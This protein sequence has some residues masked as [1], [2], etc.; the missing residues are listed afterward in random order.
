MPPEHRRTILNFSVVGLINEHELRFN[1]HRSVRFI[2]VTIIVISQKFQRIM[3]E[4]LDF[5]SN[6][7]LVKKI[8]EEFEGTTFR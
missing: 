5:I 6:E 1:Q 7:Q 4:K 2:Y 8:E 3:S